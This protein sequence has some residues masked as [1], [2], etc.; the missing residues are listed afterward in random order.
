MQQRRACLAK[1]E[2]MMKKLK[3]QFEHFLKVFCNSEYFKNVQTQQITPWGHQLALLTHVNKK[4]FQMLSH[5]GSRVIARAM[6][7]EQMNCR[8]VLEFTY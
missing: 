7:Q 4:S 8:V 1:A 3:P 5:L 2:N 6:H